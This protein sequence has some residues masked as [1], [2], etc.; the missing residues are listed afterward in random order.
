MNDDMTT[1]Q[2]DTPATPVEGEETT[3]TTETTD[4]PTV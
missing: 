3:E 4:E 2:G 1:P